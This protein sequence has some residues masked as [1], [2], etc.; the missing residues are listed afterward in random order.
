[1]TPCILAAFISIIERDPY[2]GI[3]EYIMEASNDKAAVNGCLSYECGDDEK[4]P[5]GLKS[6]LMIFNLGPNR[7]KFEFLDFSSNQAYI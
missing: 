3:K 7:F 4:M 5:L 6:M 2:L 1:M